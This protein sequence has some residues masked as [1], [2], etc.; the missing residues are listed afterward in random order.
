MIIRLTLKDGRF[1]YVSEKRKSVELISTIQGAFVYKGTLEFKVTWKCL[2][3]YGAPKLKMEY[4]CYSDNYCYRKDVVKFEAIDPSTLETKE[5]DVNEIEIQLTDAFSVDSDTFKRLKRCGITSSHSL[6]DK[7]DNFI[8]KKD[9]YAKVH[10][11]SYLARGLTHTIESSNNWFIR[12]EPHSWHGVYEVH[13]KC[14]LNP[15]IQQIFLMNLD[16][17]HQF[18]IY[19]E[20]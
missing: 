1:F 13:H 20:K 18:T 11:I 2:S 10:K 8:T 6:F 15:I 3:F 17:C 9:D 14:M 5:F 12:Y 19:E 16:S 4:Q 7:D